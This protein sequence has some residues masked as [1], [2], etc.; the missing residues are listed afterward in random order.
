M[1]IIIKDKNGNPT[2]IAGLG[3]QGPTGKSAY[4]YAIEAG[5]TGTESEFAARMDMYSNENLLDNWYFADPI[6]QQGQTEY[7]GNGQYTVDRWYLRGLEGSRI[8]VSSEGIT[9]AR[10]EG[11]TETLIAQVFEDNEF[12]ALVGKQVTLSFLTGGNELGSVTLIVDPE[13]TMETIRAKTT[14]C[15]ALLYKWSNSKEGKLQVIIGASCLSSNSAA[16]QDTI[17]AVKL[18][19]GPVQTLA[20]KEGD[21]WV[22]N[23]PP[24]N[25]ALELAK[26][27]RYY[28]RLGTLLV[29]FGPITNGLSCSS[30]SIIFQPMRAKPAVTIIN[31]DIPY[32]EII[33]ADST[34]YVIRMSDNNTSFHIDISDNELLNKLSSKTIGIHGVVLD[35]N[36]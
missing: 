27:Q 18:E 13:S 12:Q 33:P 16:L 11:E 36:L 28:H 15:H 8:A 26:C 20:H 6:N 30:T 7:T 19:L 3:K 29:A 9:F 31:F 2:H 22:L 10:Q 25:K 17:V 34:K 4:Q 24:P 5:F 1:A 32:V 14:N 23:D 35:A 21:T